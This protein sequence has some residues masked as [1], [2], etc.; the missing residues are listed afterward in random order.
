LLEASIELPNE[1]AV[2]GAAR[3]F[4]D[5]TVADWGL[6]SIRHEA[7]LI[8][9]ELSANAVLHARTDF[10]VTLRSDG[11]GYLRIEVR[12]ENSRIP[13]SPA[14]RED[15]LS[16]RGLLIVGALATRWGTQFDGV[17]KVVWAE[18]GRRVLAGGEAAD[19]SYFAR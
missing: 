5:Q 13:S 6:D 3:L 1:L 10:G 18:I 17:G 4:V 2:V 8:A 14:P 15:A 19:V 9:S 12:D 7:R 11:L 16:G